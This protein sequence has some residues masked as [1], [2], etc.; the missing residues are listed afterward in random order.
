MKHLDLSI[1]ILDSTELN[2]LKIDKMRILQIVRN[3]QLFWS[4]VDLSVALASEGHVLYE[5][6]TLC[7]KPGNRPH[8]F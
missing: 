2:L 7:R 8:T 6:E 3:V 1:L 5:A 4:F